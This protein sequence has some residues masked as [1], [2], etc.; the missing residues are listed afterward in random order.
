ML[1]LTKLKIYASIPCLH[2]I[3]IIALKCGKSIH[4]KKQTSKM[5]TKR[6]LGGEESNPGQWPWVVDLISVNPCTGAILTPT[7][8]LTAANCFGKVYK[9]YFT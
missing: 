5:N 2:Y 4:E 6:M 1:A 9:S 8:I 3:Y 7:F